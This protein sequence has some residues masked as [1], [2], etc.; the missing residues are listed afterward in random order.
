MLSPSSSNEDELWS[1]LLFPS[2]SMMMFIL[3]FP[4]LAVEVSTEFEK[5]AV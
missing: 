4:E 3:P 1:N 2:R 5:P